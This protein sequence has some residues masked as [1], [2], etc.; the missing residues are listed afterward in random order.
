MLPA[1][2]VMATLPHTGCGGSSTGFLSKR[3]R[4]ILEV[5][6]ET[7]VG[8]SEKA[9]MPSVSDAGVVGFLDALLPTLPD[10]LQQKFPLLLFGIEHG[11][12]VFGSSFSRFTK[13]GP[14]ARAAYLETY[15]TSDLEIRRLAFRALKNLIMMACSSRE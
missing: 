4:Q 1:L 9:D 2:T 13:L 11:T 15:A 7:I 10:E 8:P 3:N 6:A 5:A 14:S 12:R